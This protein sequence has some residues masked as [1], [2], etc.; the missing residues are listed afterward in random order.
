LSYREPSRISG[1]FN[2]DGRD[3]IRTPKIS[4]DIQEVRLIEAEAL[5]VLLEQRLRDPT[6]DLGPGDISGLGVQDFF[7]ESGVL[8][9]AEVREEAGI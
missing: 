4:T 6:F 8:T 5:L 1:E 2:D 9:A 3:A 7:A